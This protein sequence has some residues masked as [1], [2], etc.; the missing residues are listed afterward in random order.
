VSAPAVISVAAGQTASGV[1]ITMPPPASSPPINA[2]VLGVTNLNAAG[3][4][5][6]TGARISRGAT[7]RVIVFGA[8]LSGDLQVTIG[9]PSD[10]SVSNVRAIQSTS[11]KPGSFDAAISGDAALDWPNPRSRFA[12]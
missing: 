9:G 5:S 12:G 10:I 2:E 7:M 6:N 4:A 1:N 8:G 11:G 3:S